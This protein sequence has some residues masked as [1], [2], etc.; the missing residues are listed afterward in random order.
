LIEITYIFFFRLCNLP[1]S[2]DTDEAPFVYGYLCGLIESHHPLVLGPNNSNIP[3]LIRIIAEAFLRDA[4]DR[5]HSVAQRMIM[6]VRGIQVIKVFYVYLRLY[7][8]YAY[9]FIFI[10]KCQ[11]AI[12]I[13]INKNYHNNGML[14]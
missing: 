11:M 14:V 8:N 9:I 13:R 4:I 12:Y 7:I 1:V 2:E 5:T 6:I 10:N 3:S